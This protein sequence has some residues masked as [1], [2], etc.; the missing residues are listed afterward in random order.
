MMAPLLLA[1]LASAAGPA[2]PATPASGKEQGPEDAGSRIEAIQRELVEVIAERHR[3]QLEAV[4][5]PESQFR[6]QSDPSWSISEDG[7]LRVHDK[8]AEVRSWKPDPAAQAKA[9]TNMRNAGL[10]YEL[11]MDLQVRE[12]SPGV[13]AATYRLVQHT[14]FQGEPCTKVFRMGEVYRREGDR[15][16]VVVS[17]ETV[18]PGKPIPR[19]VDTKAYADYD[20]IY[21]LL[22][23]YTYRVTRD[24]DGLLWF[25]SEAGRVELVPEDEHTFVIDGRAH[26]RVRFERDAAGK[27]T[28]LRMIEFPGVE[29]SAIKQ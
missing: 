24:G 26:Y 13:V 12:L 21:R 16:R 19:P 1:L 8:A 6:I 20:G 17:S 10:S 9:S 23:D 11:P 29:Y 7:R 4:G 2:K 28:H 25:N 27:V 22:P 3:Q 18:I 14:R 5:D 15:W